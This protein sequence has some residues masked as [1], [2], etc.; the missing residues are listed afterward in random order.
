[1]T[2]APYVDPTDLQGITRL[3]VEATAG[4]TDLVEAM[5]RASDPVSAW[6]FDAPP[7]RAGGPAG[8]A[9]ASV[10][11]TT[12]LIG[13]G[14]DTAL[15]RLVPL[16][17]QAGASGPREAV[18]AALNGVLGDHL[19]ASGNPLAIPMTV[20]RDG[21]PLSL[22][23]AAL[24][25]ALPA[26]TGR[27][28][29][30]VHGLCMNDLQ[31]TRNGHDHGAALRRDLGYT[32]VY[33][34]YNSGRHIARN[35]R[36]LAALLEALVE[37]WP[38]PVASLSLVCHS[39][40][41]LVARSAAHHGALAAHRWPAHL[42]HLVFLATPHHGAPME[43]GGA[44]LQ[45]L[46]GVTPYTAPFGRLGRIRSAGITDLR[47][48]SL[49]DE[50]WVG[51]DRFVPRAELPQPVPLPAGVACFTVAAT[52]RGVSPTLARH[53]VGDGMVLLRSALGEDDDPARALAFPPEHRWVAEGRHHLDVLDDPEV[54]A[55]VRRWLA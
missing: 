31:W 41:G 22:D 28:A 16:L 21:T 23:R 46:L 9:Y 45:L 6:L 42:R 52:M 10:R 19:A 33:L 36:D 11:L 47:H 25:A 38:V 17:G 24:A 39:M 15:A 12:R 34:H 20:R 44:W 14:L 13:R 55:R 29:V 50:D 54:Y 3:V 27:I 4:V 51:R 32:P 49:V 2:R 26:A 48:G 7:D 5:H 37:A 40:G 30:L 1:M 18:V 43:R 35:G 8:L 53:L